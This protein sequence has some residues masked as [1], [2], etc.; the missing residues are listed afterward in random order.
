MTKKLKALI[1]EIQKMST[2]D[3]PG[4]RTT[5]FFKQCP[6]R[7]IW[8]HNPESIEKKPQ[9]QWLEHKCIGCQICIDTC[10]QG[11]LTFD[12]DGIHIN[13][14]KCVSCG[15]C[16]EE[17]PSTALNMYGKWWTLEDL[18]EEI[19]KDR[20]YYSKSGG[21][22]TVSGGE[23]TMQH[24]FVLEFLKICKEN[25]ISTALDTCGYASKEI[26]EKLLPYV[27]L[28]LLDLKVIDSEKH[29]EYTGVPNELILNNARWLA[30]Y[31]KANGKKMWIRTPIIPG[32]TATDENIKGI[33]E[34]IV[35]ELNNIPERWDLL[36]FNNLCTSKY[37]RLGLE[38]PLKDVPLMRKEEMEHFLKIA[39]DAGVKNPKWSGMTKREDSKDESIKLEKSKLPSC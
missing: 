15:R 16:V 1:F 37:E 31:V 17:C 18:F 34:F 3:G 2:E 23:P 10:K 39:I 36:A 25:G 14:E 38:W 11:A 20:V 30:E 13:R 22:I 4:I 32:Y 6:L 5:V 8:C 19:D 9:L 7:C 26:Y 28:I 27:D 12:K 29:K 24:E 33:A 35:N 21:G